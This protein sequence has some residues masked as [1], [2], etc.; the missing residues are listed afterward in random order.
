MIVSGRQ[1]EVKG[2]TIIRVPL[3]VV[4]EV[5]PLFWLHPCLKALLSIE[6]LPPLDRF[7]HMIILEG[8]VP[9]FKM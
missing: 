8:N 6:Q 3:E 7:V 9:S 4:I 2:I 5:V 1:G